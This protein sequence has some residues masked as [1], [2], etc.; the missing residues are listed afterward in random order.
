[1][2][3]AGELLIRGPQVFAGYWNN[4]RHRRNA[5]QRLAAWTSTSR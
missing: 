5:A 3:S 1:M 4:D 2:G